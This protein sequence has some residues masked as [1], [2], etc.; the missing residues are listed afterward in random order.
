MRTVFH[1][2]PMIAA[3]RSSLVLS[4]AHDISSPLVLMS[5]EKRRAVCKKRCIHAAPC[6]RAIQ[7]SHGR[8]YSWRCGFSQD[9][10]KNFWLQNNPC[11]MRSGG[12]SCCQ[13]GMSRSGLHVSHRMMGVSIGG[14]A[15]LWMASSSQYLAISIAFP[16]LAQS[17][18]SN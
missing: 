12:C 16:L 4:P 17:H 5:L 15:K 1:T 2:L 9:H 18:K 13:S 14:P 11:S 10:L 8:K 3:T 6:R 7:N